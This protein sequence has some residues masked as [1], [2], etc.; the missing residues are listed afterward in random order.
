MVPAR[1]GVRQVAIATE[2]AG[3]AVHVNHPDGGGE[4]HGLAGGRAARFESGRHSTRILRA[5]GTVS[6]R[7]AG[8]LPGLEDSET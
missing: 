2:P 7:G 1:S 8:H 4:G 5:I 3:H 6:G